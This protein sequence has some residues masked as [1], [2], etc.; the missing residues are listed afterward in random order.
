MLAQLLLV[1][2]VFFVPRLVHGLDEAA[3]VAAAIS[4]ADD[5]DLTRRIENMS[6]PEDDTASPAASAGA[7]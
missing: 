6:R 4:P 3:P 5:A 2:T 1:V 7:P